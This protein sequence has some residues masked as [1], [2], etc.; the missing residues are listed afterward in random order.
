MTLVEALRTYGPVVEHGDAPVVALT[1]KAAE[2]LDRELGNAERRLRGSFR[3]EVLEEARQCVALYL[4]VNG[5]RG[6]RPGEPD[7]DAGVT[8]WLLTVLANKAL[9][10]IKS[11]ARREVTGV[12]PA[13]FRGIPS[14]Q[15]TPY[16]KL[17]DR[18]VADLGPV[19]RARVV[20]VICR[21]ASELH[22]TSLLELLELRGAETTF[23][24]I[25]LRYGE[26]TEK[27]RERLYKRYERALEA[28]A[29]RVEVA[30]LA[31]N[32]SEE[33]RQQCL[34]C[35]NELPLSHLG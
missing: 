3:S 7:T 18:Q 29:T 2:L 30:A 11:K 32:I 28:A 34:A 27:L 35:L 33:M 14:D 31:G 21:G 24:D 6:A 5:P 12:D 10:L 4:L 25:V 1:Q 13:V 22:R 20:E 17:R 26:D 23:A 8:A 19:L 16:E 9:S 15:P